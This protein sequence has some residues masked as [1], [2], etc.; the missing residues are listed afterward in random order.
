MNKFLKLSLKA[1]ALPIFIIRVIYGALIRLLPSVLLLVFYLSEF[2]KE[3]IYDK[4][5][6]TV[7]GV[8]SLFWSLLYV[9]STPSVPRLAYMYRNYPKKIMNMIKK[10]T[11]FWILIAYLGIVAFINVSELPLYA[12]VYFAFLLISLGLNTS[13]TL[14]ISYMGYNPFFEELCYKRSADFNNKSVA[15]AY[16][17]SGAREYLSKDNLKKN[18]KKLKSDLKSNR[19]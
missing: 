14:I 2:N 9:L 17:E 8:V 7:V 13:L 19:R 10:R 18:A 5:A 12:I 16:R 15:Q 3:W 1:L 4:K 11:A 6:L